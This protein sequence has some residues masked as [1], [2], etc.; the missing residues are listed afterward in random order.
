M[1]TF[2]Q[3]F[4]QVKEI[5]HRNRFPGSR[6][7]WE[8]RYKK[9]GTSGSGSYGKLATFKAELLNAFVEQHKIQT[10]VELGCG[11]GNQLKLANYLDYSG[12]DVS[13]TAI[14]LCK[15]T[16]K[17]DGKKRFLL[18]Q[19]DC[20]VPHAELTLSL[21]VIYHL[22]EDHVFNE[23]MH[24]LFTS[25]G[26]FVIIY[27]SNKNDDQVYHEKMRDF[28]AWIGKH[29][30]DFRLNEIIKNKYPYDPADPDNTSQSD[31]FIYQR[32]NS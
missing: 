1:A 18:Y 23:Y 9:G 2:R 12:L 8:D 13:P 14:A 30:T 31:F 27:S 28:T 16:F 21:D 7:Y 6:E 24:N 20:A 3:L 19:K 25:A 32:V 26:R 11:D 5:F 29:A 17:H 4:K 10:V 22:I 15:E